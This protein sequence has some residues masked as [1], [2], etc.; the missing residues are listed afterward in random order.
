ML[1]LRTLTLALGAVAL[2]TTGMTATAGPGWPAMPASKPAKATADAPASM[3]AERQAPAAGRDALPAGEFEY[4]GGDADW[5]LR[6]HRLTLRGGHVVH[7]SECTLM[8]SAA[9][10]PGRGSLGPS[11]DQSPGA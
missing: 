5:Q 2:V 9:T 3:R 8:A 4:I 7:A 10:V 6:Q 1:N 11:G